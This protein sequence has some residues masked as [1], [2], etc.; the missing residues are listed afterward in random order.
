MEFGDEPMMVLEQLEVGHLG[1]YL[2]KN[3]RFIEPTEL[4]TY[5]W[6]LAS[7]LSFVAVKRYVHC[8]ITLASLRLGTSGSLKVCA[9]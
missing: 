8:N 9:N 4:V 7:A 1:E 2:T 6:Q 3:R 5:C